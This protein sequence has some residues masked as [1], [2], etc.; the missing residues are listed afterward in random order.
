MSDWTVVIFYRSVPRSSNGA[1]MKASD[2]QRLTGEVAFITGGASGIGLAMAGALARE[3]MSIAIADIDEVRLDEAAAL[4]RA[5]SATVLP[6]RLDVRDPDAWVR[7]I[8]TTEARLGPLFLLCNNA[9]VGLGPAATDEIAPADW[10][11]L[12]DINLGGVFL[13]VRAAVGRMKARG[14]GHIVNTSSILGLFPKAHHAAYIAAKFAVVGLSEALRAEL[15]PHGI[16][17]TVLLPGLVRTAQSASSRAQT[18]A[19]APDGGRPKP[20]GQAPKAL[21]Q[22]VVDAVRHNRLYAISHDE[23]RPVV[24]DR[25]RR[26]LA[27]FGTPPNKP[28]DILYLGHDSLNLS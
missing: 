17:V 14:H 4:L 7:A 25:M 11:W 24:E 3:G 18:A 19:S 10:Q 8:D 15:A 1:D 22:V 16:G 6:I 2:M 23:Y 21:G 13:G 9:G 12:L 26:L 27:A 28:E 5:E 20:I